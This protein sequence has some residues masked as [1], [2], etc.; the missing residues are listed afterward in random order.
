VKLCHRRSPNSSS[1]SLKVRI[2]LGRLDELG[3]QGSGR[4]KA[5]K[6]NKFKAANPDGGLGG[7]GAGRGLYT[8]TPIILEIGVSIILGLWFFNDSHLHKRAA[9]CE[10]S[11][12]VKS[13]ALRCGSRCLKKQ[14]WVNILNKDDHPFSHFW[15]IL[16]QS[17][18]SGTV[19][20]AEASDRKCR[21]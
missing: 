12:S 5:G 17:F 21:T 10:T 6:G 7:K 11:P 3:E 20:D 18:G 13:C 2:Q 1:S 9:Y 4:R 16:L 14:P 8:S 15:D 19:I